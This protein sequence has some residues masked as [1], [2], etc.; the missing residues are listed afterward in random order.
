MRS[1][2]EEF[3]CEVLNISPGGIALLAPVAGQMGERIVVYLNDLGRFE[4]ELV[5]SFNGG[6]ALRIG[7]TLHKR[8]KVANQ[9]TWILNRHQ[10]NLDED[11][12]HERIVPAK[13]SIMLT[14]S[15]GSEARARVLDVSLGGASVSVLPQPTIGEPVTIGLIR[16]TVVRHHDQGIGIRFQ[17]IQDPATIERQFG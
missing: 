8:E 3:P 12:Q 7:G 9:L 5:R 16:G 11:R 14:R 15:D 13:Q 4:G 1:D 6:F 17:E 2:K 10:L